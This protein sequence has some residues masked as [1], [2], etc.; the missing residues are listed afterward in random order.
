MK[1]KK[2]DVN[3]S[4]GKVL[5]HDITGIFPGKFKGPVFK[6]GHII[7]KEDIQKLLKL[8]KEKIWILELSNNEYHED[9]AGE[10]LKKLAGRNVLTRGPSEGKVTFV[11][12]TDGVLVIEKEI[13][14]KI[15]KIKDILFTTRHSWI[16]VRKGEELA[17]I[18]IVPLAT[19]KKRIHKVLEMIKN[20]KPINVLPFKKKKIGLIITGNEVAKGKIN[21]K[22]KP[23]IKKKIED[24]GSN[25]IKTKILPDNKELIKNEIFSMKKNC[26]FIILTGGMSVDADDVTPVAIRES[27]ARIISY[28]TPILPGNMILI[29]YLKNI[30]V[31]GVPACAIYYKITAFD[32]FLPLILADIK[33]TKNQIIERGYGGYCTHCKVC[34]FPY[35]GFGKC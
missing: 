22:F 18:R 33:I 7:K 29:A 8:G 25:I 26:N 1:K 9:E 14:H 4:L 27:G 19:S 12:K 13:V 35:C 3:E 31:L 24:Y 23:I 11:A 2:I 15:N 6:K 32:L 5:T 30:P 20:K 10:K 17:G 34:I 16:P 21:D 28:G